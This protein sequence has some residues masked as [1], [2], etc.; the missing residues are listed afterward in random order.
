M[1]TQHLIDVLSTNVEPVKPRQV[2]RTLVVALL[3][4][5]AAAL[6][7]MAMTLGPR[8][9]LAID[10]GYVAIKV[11]F[12]LSVIAAG[13][14]F[15]RRSMYPGRD[16][17]RRSYASLLFPLAM[18]VAA[19]VGAA[20]FASTGGRPHPMMEMAETHW[21]LCIVCIPLFAAL[22]FVVLLWAVRHAAPT[23]LE[24]TGAIA[25][26]VAGAT[27][28]VAYAFHC[29]DDSLPFVAIWYAGSIAL[30][31]IIGRLLGPRL[32]RW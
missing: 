1:K 5:I 16:A 29:P 28:A 32:L 11:M 21:T 30:C 24:R 8:P 18:I 25:G 4:G 13:V 3:V 6:C 19:G 26:L 2:D 15:L 17:A 9:N 27:G 12:A 14:V 23:N 22:P 20:T 10:A 7:V 31:A